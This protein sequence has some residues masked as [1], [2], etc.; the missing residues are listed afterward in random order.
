[1][2]GLSAD[3][4]AAIRRHF[5]VFSPAC[6]PEFPGVAVGQAVPSEASAEDLHG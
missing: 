2:P 5:L 4:L 3:A 6:E 1:M